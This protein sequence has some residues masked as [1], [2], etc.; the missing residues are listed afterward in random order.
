MN[1][2]RTYPDRQQL[3]EFGRKHCGVE[4]PG[5]VIERI[6]QA[7]SEALRLHQSRI[8][9]GL[10]HAMQ[11]EWDAGRIMALNDSLKTGLRRKPVFKP[12]P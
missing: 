10:Y 2:V 1:K 3:I 8:G 5:L 12:M 11:A 4:K 7:M 6:A 9:P